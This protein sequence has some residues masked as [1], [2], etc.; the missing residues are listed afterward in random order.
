MFSVARVPL[1]LLVTVAVSVV[2]DRLSSKTVD[3]SE[4]AARVRSHQLLTVVW[5]GGVVLLRT[6]SSRS[7]AASSRTGGETGRLR[8]LLEMNIVDLDPT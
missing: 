8:G 2:R 7:G 1:P 4:R 6:I 5:T 3:T